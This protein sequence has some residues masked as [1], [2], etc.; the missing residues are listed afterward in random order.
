M[1][2]FTFRFPG[3][4]DLAELA[5]LIGDKIGIKLRAKNEDDVIHGYL[6]QTIRADKNFPDGNTIL[7]VVTYGFN[8]K[9][10]WND[11]TKMGHKTEIKR[12]TMSDNDYE[13]IN[14]L[15]LSLEEKRPIKPLTKKQIDKL[16]NF[17]E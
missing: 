14:N 5:D 8:E 9:P 10:N 16:L 1:Q 7:Q 11:K 2:T 13:K 15:L 3:I 4:Y 12:Y 6:T 17:K